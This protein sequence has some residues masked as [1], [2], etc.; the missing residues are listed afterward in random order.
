MNADLENR[1]QAESDGDSRGDRRPSWRRMTPRH[2]DGTHAF[3][4]TKEE[5]DCPRATELLFGLS[6]DETS[7]AWPGIQVF[8]Q[9]L[10][11]HFKQLLH[12]RFAVIW[13]IIGKE[14]PLSSADGWRWCA[15]VLN[16]FGAVGDDDASMDKAYQQLVRN[17]LL[18]GGEIRSREKNQ[19]LLAM[20][21]IL[22][23]L[24][25]ALKPILD[26]PSEE[27]TVLTNTTP[28]GLTAEASTR[29][30]I[31]RDLRRPVSKMFY[32]YRDQTL[33]TDR[34]ASRDPLEQVD[35]WN[36]DPGPSSQIGT[37]TG[38]KTGTDDVLYV[39]SLEYFAL[40]TIGRVRLKWVETL[41]DH[42]AFDRSKHTLSVF[43][44]PSFCVANILRK[45]EVSVI[46]KITSKLLP[47][48][49]EDGTLRDS[50]ELYREV[51]LSYRLLFGQSPKSRR[52]VSQVPSRSPGGTTLGDLDP[53]LL[54]ICTSH[55]T[56]G[57]LWNKCPTI[58]GNLFP[59][60]VLDFGN[61]LQESDT[62]SVQD[63]FPVFGRRLLKLQRYNLRQRPSK[64]KD[65]WRDKRN[66][67]QWYTFWAVLWVGGLSI[68]LATLQLFLGA[69][70]LYYA[71]QQSSNI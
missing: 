4:Q 50:P 17:G 58:S 23:W 49:N 29:S 5:T 64:W 57:W 7:K 11:T 56:S 42:L 71:I 61:N 1:G 40:F 19:V 53:F 2:R 36:T 60:S 43:R 68:F 39:S 22:C 24:S 9:H 12:P 3:E 37:D 51:L 44:Y 31:S 67:L 21:A 32:A 20:F 18:A 55:L 25:A 13:R 35:S 62:Y 6:S 63:D 33:V 46:K 30:Y 10:E 52:L 15:A 38:S 28:F 27:E 66:P 47:S 59:I 48:Y 45:N 69:A 16:A 34:W 14:P 8:C 65:L 26:D 54:T 70:Q 41:S